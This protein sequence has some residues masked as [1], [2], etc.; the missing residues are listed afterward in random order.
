MIGSTRVPH[1]DVGVSRTWGDRCG[2]FL[3]ALRKHPS[4]ASAGYYYH[5]HVDYFDKIARSIYNIAVGLKRNGSAVFVV[6]DSYY[7]S[8][9]NDLPSIIAD[10]AH[11]CGLALRRRE[12]FQLNRSMAGINRH[13]QVYKRPPGAVEAVLCFQK[14]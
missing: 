1:R 2:A 12:D 9:H 8:L 10:I 14:Q 11:G 6:Q 5:T 13:T 4:K 3:E 7:K